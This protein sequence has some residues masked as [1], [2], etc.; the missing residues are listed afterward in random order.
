MR[1]LRPPLAATLLIEKL[2]KPTRE[3]SLPVPIAPITEE[4]NVSIVFSASILVQLFCLATY[5]INSILF[6]IL[7]VMFMIKSQLLYSVND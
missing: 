7:L 3:T 6:V 5:V 2:P 4:V 1:G